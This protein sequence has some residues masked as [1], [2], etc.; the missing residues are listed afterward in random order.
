[1]TAV[2]SVS[3]LICT[4]NRDAFLA[5]TLRALSTAPC[6]A[7][8]DVE[9]V[10]VDNNS[11]DDTRR[12]VSE[13]AAASPRPIR[14]ALERR[15]GKSFAL[16]HGLELVR[17]EVVALTDDDVLIAPEW[18]ARIVAAF[19]SRDVTYAFGKVLP[20]WGALPPPELLTRRG[21]DMWGPLAL[22]DYGDEPV[23]YDEA[24]FERRPFPIGA[25]LAFRRD[26][27]ERVGGWRTDLGKVDNTLISGEDHEIFYRLYHAG[28]YRGFYD[29]EL[30]VRHYVPPQRLTRQYFRRWFYWHG[31]TLARMNRA[32][33]PNLD[34]SRVAH[35]AGVPRYMYRQILGQTWRWVR[36]FG[37]ND[38]LGLLIE[39]MRWIEDVGYFAECWR[40]GGTVRSGLPDRSPAPP[41]ADAGRPPAQSPGLKHDLE[42]L[43]HGT[44]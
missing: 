37:T 32:I 20:R 10:V 17:G 19:E 40:P 15:Q 24:T 16:N 31:R 29:P 3:V 13:I 23:D 22:V 11:T 4:Y 28:L 21:R 41:H 14:Y 8:Y 30:V 35:I 42:E 27:V 5:E 18:I 34:W 25:N 26:A 2:R 39:E 9:I 44:L 43:K 12:V 33:H 1:M 6:P 36:R 38:A 7:H